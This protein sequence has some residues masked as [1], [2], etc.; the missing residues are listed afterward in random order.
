MHY[1]SLFVMYIQYLSN[2][3][4]HICFLFMAL[5]FHESTTWQK[6]MIIFFAKLTRL[7][8]Q[9]IKVV[10]NS[11]FY[12]HKVSRIREIHETFIHIKSGCGTLLMENNICQYTYVVISMYSM[13]SK[14]L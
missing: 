6:F 10:G 8:L 9:D 7:L 2:N 13:P 14:H 4:Y 3:N 5:K 11:Q 1:K 12:F